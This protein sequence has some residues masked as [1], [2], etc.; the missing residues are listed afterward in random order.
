M[1]MMLIILIYCNHIFNGKYWAIVAQKY[2]EHP[3]IR[4]TGFRITEG[5]LYFEV[6][7][8]SDKIMDKIT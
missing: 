1:I 4:F 3:G 8:R 5:S 7:N 2:P 6:G